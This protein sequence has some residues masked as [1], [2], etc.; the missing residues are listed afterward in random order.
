ML[1]ANLVIKKKTAVSITFPAGKIALIDIEIVSSIELKSYNNTVQE[2]CFLTV[3][4]INWRYK[5]LISK[6]E[7]ED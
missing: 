1:I 3:V 2:K 4:E 7:K 6:E 5:E